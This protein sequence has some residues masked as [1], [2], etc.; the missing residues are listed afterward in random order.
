MS[1]TGI[2]SSLTGPSSGI[3]RFC[4]YFGMSQGIVLTTGKATSITTPFNSAT[5]GDDHL[6]VGEAGDKVSLKIT[7]TAN[8]PST[9]SFNYV[10]ASQETPRYFGTNY[11]DDFKILVDGQNVAKLPNGKEVTINNLGGNKD[12]QSTWSDQ[13]VLNQNAPAGTCAPPSSTGFTKRQTASTTV[14]AG[15]HTL[16]F[17][18]EDKYDGRM[19]SIVFI[20]GN[21]IKLTRRSGAAAPV[22]ETAPLSPA[23]QPAEAEAAAGG[24]SSG[25]LIA[26]LVSAGVVLI[27]MMAAIAMVAHARGFAATEAEHLFLGNDISCQ[28]DE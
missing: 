14:Q 12:D 26:C 11:N 19:D 9:L 25:L 13:F 1:G 27:G 8:G 23:S 16:E 2:S 21:S 4:G 18:V 15:T 28:T 10:F 24:A 5:Q 3:S 22:A 20:E 6:P 7:F 17:F